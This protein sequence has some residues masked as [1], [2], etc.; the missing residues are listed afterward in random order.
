[1]V[2][3][4]LLIFLTHPICFRLLEAAVI[5]APARDIELVDVFGGRV[6]VVVLLGKMSWT[7]CLLL[8]PVV[9]NTIYFLD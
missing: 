4:P 2:D 8:H 3:S 5:L 1:M 6:E 9:D 7:G